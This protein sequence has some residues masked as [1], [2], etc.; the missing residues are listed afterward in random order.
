MLDSLRDRATQLLIDTPNC[1]LATSGPAGVQ[2]STVACQLKDDALI[3][4]LPNTSDHLFNLEHEPEVA[5]AAEGWHLQGTAEI[6]G[7]ALD[8]FDEPELQWHIVVKVTPRQMHILADQTVNHPQT[9][10]F[11]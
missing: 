6:I 11:Y 7:S 9:I 1:T 8:I 5:L 4:L 2:A 3:L 10:D